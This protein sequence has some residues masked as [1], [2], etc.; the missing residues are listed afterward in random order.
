MG[1]KSFSFVRANY[2][3]GKRSKNRCDF[4]TL[5][6]GSHFFFFLHWLIFVKYQVFL[7]KKK[8]EK[9]NIWYK[10]FAW[11]EKKLRQRIDL[12]SCIHQKLIADVDLYL[13]KMQWNVI[14]I[15]SSFILIGNCR[16]IPQSILHLVNNSI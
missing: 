1:T 9:K 15:C 14:Q 16:T 7:F 13:P 2:V 12:T 6:P 3:P 10:I 11:N 5:L 4:F 8:R